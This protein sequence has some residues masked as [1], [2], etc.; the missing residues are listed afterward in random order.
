MEH[1]ERARVFGLAVRGIIAARHEDRQPVVGRHT[2]LMRENPR[3]DR[4]WL[5]HFLAERG[6]AIDA[7]DA[8]SARIVERHEH[9]L[10]RDIGRQ[11]NGARWQ[12]NGLAVRRQGAGSIDAK[13]T[14][15][16]LVPTTPPSPAYCYSM[17]HRDTAVMHAATHTA[18][19]PA[20]SRLALTQLRAWHVN[21]I[22]RERGSDAGIEGDLAGPSLRP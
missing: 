11:V 17:P 20:V 21:V 22:V 16:M 1:L 8:Q 3:V 13:G 18:Y 12:R 10:G 14:H 2:H 19:S 9:I 4:P 5:L 6:V 15:M 7:V